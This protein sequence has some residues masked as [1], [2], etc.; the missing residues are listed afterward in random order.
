ML[1]LLP[2]DSRFPIPDWS[3]V[4]A[5]APAA[6][7]APAE[8]DAFW[9]E[10]GREWVHL[11]KRAFGEGYQGYESANFWL[12]S[13]EPADT[14]RRLVVWAEQTA[15]KVKK[16]L[17]LDHAGRLFG[18][19]PM[20]V[21]HDL[22]T[23]HEYFAAYLPDGEYAGSGGVYLNRGYGHFVFSFLDMGQA[24]AVLAHELTHA[25]VAHLPIPAWLN[26]GVAQLCEIHVTG[27]DHARY[28]EIKETLGEHWTPES[29][30]AFWSGAAF[31]E[32]DD[33]GQM[34]SY[35]LAK[36]LTSRLAR[37]PDLFHDF[38][39]E[40]HHDDA[41]AAALRARYQLSPGDLVADYL[42]DGDW[43]PRPPFAISA[44]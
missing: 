35:H 32:N 36:V 2:T 44:S 40:A 43:E 41:G 15:A 28:E 26:E 8:L 14:C 22:D 34:H 31:L 4:Q 10:Q 12:V 18:K 30:Q 42:G 1:P 23:Y 9:T 3:A 6:D 27:R 17:R 21:V 7:A 24:E 13:R 39:H 20:V 11:L 25:C 38:L 37:R 33:I 5:S 29:I 19:C 16:L